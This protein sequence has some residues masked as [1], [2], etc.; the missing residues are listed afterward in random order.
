MA[1]AAQDQARQ[2]NTGSRI[3][4]LKDA[5]LD[6]IEKAGAQ[7]ERIAESAADQARETGEQVR[8]VVSTVDAAVRQSLKDQ[9][10]A[11]LAV[12]AALGFV[13]GA[14]WKSR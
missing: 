10:L 5:A 6:Q 2:A 12:V 4:D 11:T 13:L 7:A 14:L 1:D 3:G 9:P 8:E